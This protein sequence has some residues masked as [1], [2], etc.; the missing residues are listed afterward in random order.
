ML[1]SYL[2]TDEATINRSGTP[3]S[4]V[5]GRTEKLEAGVHGRVRTPG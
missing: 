5:S 3:A 1:E 4:S 2:G